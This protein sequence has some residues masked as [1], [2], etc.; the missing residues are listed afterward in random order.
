LVT[1]KGELADGQVFSTWNYLSKDNR[2]PFYVALYGGRGVV[3]GE[4]SFRDVPGKSDVDGGAGL[5]WYKPAN[6]GDVLYP[7]GWAD[8][9]G[10]GLVG[11]KFLGAT[12]TTKTVL[13]NEAVAH[14]AVNALSELSYGGLDRVLSNRLSVGRTA[15]GVQGAPSGGT[16]ALGESIALG[17]TGVVSG[18]FAYP[19]WTG[20]VPFRGVVLQK[21]QTAGG[22]F[23]APVVG[24]KPAESGLLRLLPQ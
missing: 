13:G 15:V 6:A 1:L 10:L 5:R 8:G 18:R 21:S 7:E 11:S 17:S 2:V 24:E 19:G 16:A 3:A 9:I 20:S 14:P 22:Y 23:V 4:L 12:A